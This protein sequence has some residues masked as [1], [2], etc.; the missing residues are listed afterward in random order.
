MHKKNL[1]T[2]LR[3]YSLFLRDR[4]VAQKVVSYGNMM[5]GMKTALIP[6]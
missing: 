6:L 5:K 3:S 4:K 1:Y 2:I